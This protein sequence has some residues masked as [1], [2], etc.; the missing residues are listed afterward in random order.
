MSYI[1][2][3]RTDDAYNQKYLDKMDKE[4]LRG[5]DWCTQMAVDNFFDNNFDFDDD[6]YLSHI[7]LQPVPESM[8]EEYNLERGF[9]G[10]DCTIDH[11]TVNTYIDYIRCKILEW[12]E[13]NRNELVTSMIDGMGEEEYDKIKE[14]VD[15]GG[16]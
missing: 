2:D 12:I 4:F 16:N 14:E 10:D 9:F 7:L 15:N 3:C 6:S 11:R 8:K 1:P 5:Y 13:M